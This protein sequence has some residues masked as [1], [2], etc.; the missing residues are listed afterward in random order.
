LGGGKKRVIV[1]ESGPSDQ[2]QV[3]TP[4]FLKN[5][6]KVAVKQGLPNTSSMSK[7]SHF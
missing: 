1:F 6:L 5:E 2:E 3:S 7:I 4:G